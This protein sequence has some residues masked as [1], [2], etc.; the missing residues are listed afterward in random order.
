MQLWKDIERDKYYK[1]DISQGGQKRC[2][3]NGTPV[4]KF[5]PEVTGIYNFD[6]R[7][8]IS[9]SVKGKILPE[10]HSRRH[11][12]KDSSTSRMHGYSQMPEPISYDSPKIENMKISIL[13]KW[14]KTNFGKSKGSIKLDRKTLISKFL[15]P[16][17]SLQTKI[18][19]NF[20][21]LDKTFQPVHRK[22]NSMSTKPS[23][24]PNTNF[25]WPTKNLNI[26]SS[27]INSGLK[28]DKNSKSPKQT[29]VALR[30]NFS[31]HV[32]DLTDEAGYSKY[33]RNKTLA[34]RIKDETVQ[35]SH[36][37][38]MREI[39]NKS[40]CDI[41]QQGEEGDSDSDTEDGGD[42]EK[43]NRLSVD[44]LKGRMNSKSNVY[45]TSEDGQ[46]KTFKVKPRNRFP[47]HIQ[48]ESERWKKDKNWL[49]KANPTAN[50]AIAKRGEFDLKMLMKRRKQRILKIQ[51][52]E[53]DWS[54]E[55]NKN[56]LK[57]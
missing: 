28:I 39:M 45:E 11:F 29:K 15:Q 51:A 38:N 3:Q 27:Y 7:A 56:I 24:D 52:A 35:A 53:A 32:H 42:K 47:I 36:L 34:E 48:T 9:N 20:Q 18:S 1:I 12:S 8:S 5:F 54:K 55:N 2:L 19:N 4:T 17:C 10:L 44:K 49:L 22:F 33:K 21:D 37:K 31:P 30:K 46:R 43:P 57:F 40:I 23:K 25:D 41:V 16:K 50:Q 13:S 14:N 6:Q 26:L